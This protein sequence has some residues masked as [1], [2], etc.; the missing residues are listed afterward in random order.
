MSDGIDFVKTT[1]EFL[2]YL[3]DQ[4][5]EQ[6]SPLIATIKKL[7]WKIDLNATPQMLNQYMQVYKM[8]IKTTGM[9]EDFDPI[10]NLIPQ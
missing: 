8:L 2:E 6:E 9:A 3:G 7:A 1:D 10:E 4:L 5:T